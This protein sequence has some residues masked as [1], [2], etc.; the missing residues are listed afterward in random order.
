[1]AGQD[2]NLSETHMPQ[3]NTDTVKHISTECL[4]YQEIRYKLNISYNLFR[5]LAPNQKNY[6]SANK[7]L[8]FI[9]IILL[10]ILS[11]NLPFIA[12]TYINR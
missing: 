11:Y 1:M 10:N 3:L 12:I 7:T 6:H 4:K 9:K 2:L 8:T 5:F